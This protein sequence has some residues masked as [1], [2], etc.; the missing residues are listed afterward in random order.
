MSSAH[1]ALFRTWIVHRFNT[2]ILIFSQA[3]HFQNSC[4][5]RVER[6]RAILHFS[7]ISYRIYRILN[8]KKT[9][10][11]SSTVQYDLNKKCSYCCIWWRKFLLMRS[12]RDYFTFPIYSSASAMPSLS[13]ASQ[14]HNSFLAW[15]RINLW[16]HAS[17][18]KLKM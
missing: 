16:T 18:T 9:F 3:P 8:K 13:R 14:I 5:D 15:A 6:L 2:I 10:W 7:L 11:L 1:W 12:Y 4:N 17:I